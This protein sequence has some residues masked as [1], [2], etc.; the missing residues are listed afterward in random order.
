MPVFDRFEQSGLFW[1]YS[2][3][4][5]DYLVWKANYKTLEEAADGENFDAW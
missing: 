4:A 3:A 1:A 2:T 5:N